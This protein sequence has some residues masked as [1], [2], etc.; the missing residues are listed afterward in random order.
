MAL[1]TATVAYELRFDAGRIC[2]DLLATTHPEE[3]LDST[4]VLG[5]WIVGSGLVPEGTDLTHVDPSWLVGFRE[6]RGRI[7]QLVRGAPGHGYDLAL[8]GV[9]D[10][11][12]AAPP[13]PRAVPAEDGSLIRELDGP[14]DCA[15]L[16]GAIARDAVGLLTDPVA[17]AAVR[18]CEG[19]NCPIVYLDTSRGRRRRWCSSEVCGNRE[20]VARHRRRAAL[21]RS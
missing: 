4:E 2:L 11:A 16:L 20:R 15:A 21:S 3:R 1:G 12:R 17:R 13:A 10:A 6:L 18:E 14:P 7:A 9:N 19:D 5:A 8:A